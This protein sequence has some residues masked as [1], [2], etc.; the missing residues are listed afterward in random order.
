MAVV[1]VEQLAVGILQKIL[2]KLD[3]PANEYLNKLGCSGVRCATHYLNLTLFFVQWE[4]EFQTHLE[5]ERFE[6]LI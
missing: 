2:N 1:E 6:V 5:T 3:C 4:L